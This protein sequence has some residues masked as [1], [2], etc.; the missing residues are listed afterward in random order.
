MELDIIWRNKH[1][2]IFIDVM[3]ELKSCKYYSKDWH[4]YMID[5]EYGDS[6]GFSITICSRC[7][8]PEDYCGCFDCMCAN[9]HDE[10]N[11]S[12]DDIK[13]MWHPLKKS[14]EHFD[15]VHDECSKC[16]YY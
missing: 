3:R 11:C 9:N 14:C 12:Y 10:P 1:K 8:K 15:C 16:D 5:A 6:I 7:T 4:S 2:I 13:D